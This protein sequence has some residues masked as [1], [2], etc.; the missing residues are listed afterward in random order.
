M[1]PFIYQMVLRSVCAEIQKRYKKLW[2][3]NYYDDVFGMSQDLE[4]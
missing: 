2:L 4:H 3:I 1:S